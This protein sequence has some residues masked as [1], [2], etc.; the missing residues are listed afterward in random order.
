[1]TLKIIGAVAT[2]IE[3]DWDESE[4]DDSF[5]GVVEAIEGP[6]FARR[7][8]IGLGGLELRVPSGSKWLHD[9]HLIVQRLGWDDAK[10]LCKIGSHVNV[11]I[12][13]FDHAINSNPQ[14]VL[15]LTK[16]GKSA[17]EIS[18]SLG[19][20]MRHVRRIKSKLREEGRLPQI[21][22]SAKPAPRLVQRVNSNAGLTGS[23]APSR[24]SGTP[25]QPNR[26]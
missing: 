15:D 24:Q 2:M 10:K 1:M 6:D 22:D 9:D 18:L 23:T 3:R 14:R 21:E 26:S 20:S 7:V 11:A 12:P 4:I 17:T 13:F 16:G 8:K 25:N 5:M 19:I